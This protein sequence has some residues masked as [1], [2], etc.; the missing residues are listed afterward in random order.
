[1]YRLLLVDDEEM[2][3]NGLYEIFSNLKE[4]DLDICKAYSAEEALGWLNRTRVDVVLCDIRMP[5]MDGLQLM[6][7]IH[8]SWPNCKIIFLTGHSEFEYVYRAIQHE[9]TSYLL[10]NEDPEKVI[11]AVKAAIDNLQKGLKIDNLL[12]LAREQMTMAVDLF[13]NDFLTHLLHEKKPFPVDLEQFSKL[14]IPMQPHL[15]VVLLI[16]HI[17]GMP[18]EKTYWDNINLIYSVRLIMNQHLGHL[19]QSINTMDDDYDFIILLQPRELHQ[20]TQTKHPGPFDHM[21]TMLRGAL[22][23]IQSACRESAQLTIHFALAGAPCAWEELSGKYS[24]LKQLLHF[25]IG[26]GIESILVDTDV[27]N[28]LSQSNIQHSS[29]VDPLIET[30]QRQRSMHVLCQYL[31]SGKR[32]Q[33]FRLFAEFIDPLRSIAEKDST[34]AAEAYFKV[35]LSLLSYMNRWRTNDA[36]PALL[37]QN[38]LMDTRA[39]STWAQAAD[40]LHSLSETLFQAQSEAQKN[41]GDTTILHLQ[42]YIRDHLSEDLSLIR[43]AEQVYL[44][45]SYLSRL[46]RQIKGITLSDYIEQERILKAK[47]LL[48]KETMKINEVARQT[49]YE[50]AASFTRFFK[51]IVGC[52]PLDYQEGILSGKKRSDT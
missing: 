4:M 51:K 42:R 39:Y 49:G 25:R 6:A 46:F 41:R 24:T 14:D 47:E 32:D 29:A 7:E 35:A 52:S 44:N 28:W 16:G 45:P 37:Q 8:R 9:N 31:E 20:G 36:L 13:Q 43:L 17:D 19:A 12:Q 30:L 48:A 3:V 33:Y 2:I 50:T 18:L 11:A 5:G 21:I 10:K 15:P 27:Q 1:M 40:T 23:V 22:E 34:I 26:K 38:R